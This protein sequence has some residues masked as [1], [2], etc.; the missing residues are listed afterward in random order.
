MVA[1]ARY[2]D[3]MSDTIGRPEREETNEYYHQYIDLVPAGDIRD[4]LEAQREEILAFYNAIPEPRSTHRYAP[5]KWSVS[6]V[7]GH[8]NDAERLYTMR[9]FWFARGMERPMPSFEGDDA[10]ANAKAEERPWSSHIHEFGSI[11]SSTIDL[12]RYLPAEAWVRRG[13]ASDYPF[14]VRSLAYIAVGHVRHHVQIL[15][16]RYL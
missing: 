13:I 11:R 3:V 12:F 9:A 1:D 15:R 14:T 8:I 16:E 6:E 7:L 5:G 4:I 2:A 10:V